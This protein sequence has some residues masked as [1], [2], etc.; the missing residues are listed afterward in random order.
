[1]LNTTRSTTSRDDLRALNETIRRRQLPGW[2]LRTGVLAA[3]AIIWFWVC[4]QIL[5]AGSLIRYDGLEALGQE[6]VRLLTQ[7]NPYLWWGVIAILSLIVLS[8]ARAWFLR[9]AKRSRTALV[10]VADIQKLATLMSSEGIQVLKWVWD[11]TADPV[12]VGDLIVTRQEIQSGRVR[13]LAMV[14]SQLQA[15]EQ[16]GAKEGFNLRGVR[17]EP[18]VSAEAGKDKVEPV[19]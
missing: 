17:A 18:G 11:A 15:L 12:T 5:R 16:G 2:L 14:Q 10:P 1:M 6:V 4:Q 8:V 3:V 19:L 7:I 13:K 9:S